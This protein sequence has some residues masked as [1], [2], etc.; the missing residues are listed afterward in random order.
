M[1]NSLYGNRFIEKLV[2]SG[3]K[4]PTYAM[5]EIIDNSVDA[6]AKNIDIVIVEEII[7][8]GGKNS[9]FISDVFF[10]DD[11]TGMNLK[12]I[13]GCLKF[14]EGAGTSDSRIGTFG[15]GLPNSSIFV[16]RRAEV[17]SKD[18]VTGKWN[19][20]FLDLDDQAKRSE[21]GYD[22]AI[23]KKPNFN[24]IYLGDDL[25]KNSTIIRWSKIRNVGAKRPDTVIDRTGKLIGRLY[26][27]I[28][29]EINICFGATIKGNKGFDIPLT[30][31]LVFDPLFLIKS[32]SQHT[33]TMWKLANATDI[34]KPKIQYNPNVPDHKEFN[35]KFHYGKY[36][37]GCKKNETVRPLFQKNDNYWDEKISVS[38]SGKTYSYLI[39]ASFSTKSIAH[40]GIRGGGNTEIGQLI[41]TKMVGSP[42]FTGGNMFYKS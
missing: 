1:S 3:Y 25:E 24:D 28:L 9:R 26:R 14:S 30:K 19:F 17:Y 15:V 8:E 33:E 31:V 42:H 27:Y 4:N 20:V 37:E 34:T 39:R 7:K 36:I 35:T 11:G 13:N 22:E 32:K 16:G 40:P 23:E 10:I 12:E 38:I 29:D 2:S 41:R 21:S 5:A 18:K 6:K